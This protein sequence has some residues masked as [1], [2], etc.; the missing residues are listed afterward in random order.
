MI[1]VFKCIV[2]G[3]TYAKRQSV[4]SLLYVIDVFVAVVAAEGKYK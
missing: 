4:V 3:Q 1:E 2:T